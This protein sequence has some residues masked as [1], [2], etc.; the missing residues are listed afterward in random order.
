MHPDLKKYL[1]YAT[2]S[3]YPYRNLGKKRGHLMKNRDP[4]KSWCGRTLGHAT[5]DCSGAC[6]RCVNF[7]EGNK[8]LAAS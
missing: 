8:A 2:P 4:R 1:L 6:Q 3:A 5:V 7:Y